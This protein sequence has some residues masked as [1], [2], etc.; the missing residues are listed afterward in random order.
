VGF[1]L[2]LLVDE[3]HQRRGYGRALLHELLR[4]FR[5]DPNVEAVAT[6]HRR[7]NDAMAALCRSLG[8]EPWD[9]PWPSDDEDDVFLTLSV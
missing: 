9:T 4:R 1:I 3:A 5:L 7:G 8:F 6:S 2:R